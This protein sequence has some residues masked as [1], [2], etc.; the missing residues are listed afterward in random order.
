MMFFWFGSALD[1]HSAVFTHRIKGPVIDWMTIVQKTAA[2][3][4]PKAWPS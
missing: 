2:R 1:H 4:T 3:R